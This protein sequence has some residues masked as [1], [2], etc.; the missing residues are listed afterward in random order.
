MIGD[1]APPSEGHVSGIPV[2]IYTLSKFMAWGAGSIIQ[3]RKI[4]MIYGSMATYI[5]YEQ[6]NLNGLLTCLDGSIWSSSRTYCK[7]GKLSSCLS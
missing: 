4:V 2:C 1:L 5:L 7:D 6:F 3:H